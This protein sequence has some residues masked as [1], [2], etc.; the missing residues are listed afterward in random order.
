M[1]AVVEE[2]DERELGR[3]SSVLCYAASVLAV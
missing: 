1:V 3:P 2:E